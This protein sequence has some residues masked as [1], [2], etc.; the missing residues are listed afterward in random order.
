MCALKS[1]RA[2]CQAGANA[3]AAGDAANAE[4]ILRQA[5]AEARALQSPILEAKI[6]NTMAVFAMEDG[7]AKTAV[8]LLIKALALVD[9]RVGRS[10]KLYTTLSNNLLQAEM[11]RISET[12][13]TETAAAETAA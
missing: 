10:N 5:R 8:P 13:A 3:H 12:A 11:A 1:I 4:F 6:C 9:A 7:R 2:L